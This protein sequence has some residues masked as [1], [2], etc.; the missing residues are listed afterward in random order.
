[1]K[2]PYSDLIHPVL[3]TICE[4]PEGKERLDA[5]DKSLV[6]GASVLKEHREVSLRLQL[7]AGRYAIVPCTRNQG[8][9]GDYTLSIYFSIPLS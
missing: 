2:F 3:F 7:K 4:L 6:K 1:M 5:F 8:E 9:Y